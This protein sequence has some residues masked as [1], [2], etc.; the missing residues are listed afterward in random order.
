MPNSQPKIELINW[1]EVIRMLG[2]SESTLER[3]LVRD[4]NFPLPR[5]LG[6][7]TVRWLQHE[8]ED[9]IRSLEIVEYF[10]DGR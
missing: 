8:V 6:T 3:M 5:R 9:Y 2:I 10:G 4:E 7:R 1:W